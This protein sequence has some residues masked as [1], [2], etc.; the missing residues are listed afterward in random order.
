MQKMCVPP[1]HLL[2]NTA[3]AVALYFLAAHTDTTVM[4]QPTAC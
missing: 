1:L 4:Q 3:D 2:A